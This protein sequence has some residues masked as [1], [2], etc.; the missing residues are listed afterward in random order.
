[1]IGIVIQA[2]MGSHRLPGKVLASL[3]DR[4][5][6]EWLIER[7]ELCEE[8]DA[9]I[10]AT[11]ERPED[12][13]IA[14]YCRNEQVDLY[15]G[16]ENDV[17]ARYE[18]AA[19]AYYLTTVVRVTADCPFLDPMVVDRMI[20]EYHSGKWD[21]CCNINPPTFP[22]GM[23]VEVFSRKTLDLAHEQA[24]KPYDREHATGYITDHSELFRLGNVTHQPNLALYRLTIDYAE[25]LVLLNEVAR[26]LEP[27]HG[28]HFS[29]EDIVA[30]LERE[31]RLVAINAKY[32]TLDHA[33]ILSER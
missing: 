7:L 24:T 3:G 1:M 23:D 13:V 17:L 9:L 33:T 15:R 26:R 8:A 32:A 30:L 11:T 31:P 25:D 18:E 19:R 4:P 6:L 5:A 28:L 29:M 14:E 10:V 16:P 2:R 12:D 22:D 20:R 21:Y 27:Q